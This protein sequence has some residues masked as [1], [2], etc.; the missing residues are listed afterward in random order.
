MSLCVNKINNINFKA[1]EKNTV[2]NKTS[3]PDV[4]KDR[5]GAFI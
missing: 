3:K 5:G 2:E 1:N 4:E